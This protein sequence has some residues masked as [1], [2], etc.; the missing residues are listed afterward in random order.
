[1]QSSLSL[2]TELEPLFI[3]DTQYVPIEY[4]EILIPKISQLFAEGHVGN[5]KAIRP[6]VSELAHKDS[7]KLFVSIATRV[8]SN[9]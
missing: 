4:N 7:H 3:R 1:M 6:R 8:M 5:E 9:L 2:V